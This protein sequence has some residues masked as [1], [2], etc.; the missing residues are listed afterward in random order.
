MVMVVGRDLWFPSQMNETS[1]QKADALQERT[2]Q[3]ALRIIRFVDALPQTR[4]CARPIGSQLVRSATSVGANYRAARRGRSR[5]EFIAK[6]CIVVEEADE[7]LYWLKIA[8]GAG[9]IKPAQTEEL[10]QE[11]TELLAIFAKTRRTLRSERKLRVLTSSH[12]PA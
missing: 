6:M 10:I 12:R 2:F 5:A 4:Q 7:T 9:L 3:F 11:S 1:S 8:V